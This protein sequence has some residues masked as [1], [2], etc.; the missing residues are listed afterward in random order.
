MKYIGS[1]F[2]SLFFLTF[3]SMNVFASEQQNLTDPIEK[4]TAA[5][6]SEEKEYSNNELLIKFQDIATAADKKRIFQLNDLKEVD[7]LKMGNISLVQVPKGME[8]EALAQE[9]LKDKLVEHVEPNYHVESTFTP[10]DSGYKK[11]W[12]LK[13]IEASNAWNDTKGSPRVKVAI[14]DGGVQKNHPEFKGKIVDPFNMVTNST[15]YSADEHG[16]HVAGIIAARNNGSGT[17]GVAPNVKIMPINV[18]QG[19]GAEM[20]TIVKAIS[21]AIDHH[22][23]IINMSL[24]S[25]DYSSILKDAVDTA[26]SNG[27]VVVA[28]AGNND[29]YLKSY[30]ASF[31]SAIAVSAT[32]S[33]DQISY[34]SNYGSYIDLSAPGEDIYSTVPTNKY[35]SMDGTSM[36]SPVVSGVAA[37]VLSKNPF[38][39]PEKVKDILKKSTIDLGRKGWDS[40]YGYGRIDAYKAVKNTTPAVRDMKATS[41]FTMQGTNKAGISFTPQSGTMVSVY[42]KNA[43][44]EVIRKLSS[45]KNSTGKKMSAYWDGKWD[46]GAYASNGTYT[47]TIHLKTSKKEYY[48]VKSI[49]VVNQVKPAITL[50]Q[51]SGEFS[52]KV[53]KISIPIKLNENARISVRVYD[54][55]GKY[56]R[57]IY[58]GHSLYGGRTYNIYW[59]GKNNV[60]RILPDGTYKV[61][62]TIIDSSKLKGTTKYYT[63]KMDSTPPSG[64]TLSAVPNY[65]M[66]GTTKKVGDLTFKE[67][68][69]ATAYI[70]T[71]SGIKV[72]QLFSNKAI[73]P[74]TFEITWDGTNDQKTNVDEGTYRLLVQ[75]KDS[76]GNLATVTSS[77]ITVEDYTKPVVTS[78]ADFSYDLKDK[79]TIPYTLSKTGNVTVEMKNGNTVIYSANLNTQTK[80][81][82]NFTWDSKDQYGNQVA[83]G[84]YTFSIKLQDARDTGEF[85]G[86][87]HVAR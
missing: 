21:Y 56:S 77:D 44:G 84:N 10:S 54:A 43:K 32:D 22:A 48:R 29:T 62:F 13:T 53:K 16:T 76:V 7:Q 66:D 73:Q 59:D 85:V 42:V 35:E 80:G 1:V 74:S 38:L 30:P 28:A 19:T 67:N 45:N 5:M 60:G 14:I 27:V 33:S 18:F 69:S 4:S 51:T 63:V 17:V 47:I 37:L 34:F 61:Q 46:N 82:H 31:D 49:K 23:D 50:Y 81:D 3:A 26:K 41:T 55:K 75:L 11:Q 83:D 78:K 79:L 70:T 15:S 40:L 24:V 9:L 2:F 72:K 71:T 39:S 65:I 36:A 52:P 58:S 20:M 8:L 87:I 6:F 57:T 64:N 86:E 68:V 12:Y 25:Y